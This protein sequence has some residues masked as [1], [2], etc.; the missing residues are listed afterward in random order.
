M[1]YVHFKVLIP[2]IFETLTFSL[3]IACEMI[4]YH[5]SNTAPYI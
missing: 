1:R 5:T 3:A 4:H 2:N